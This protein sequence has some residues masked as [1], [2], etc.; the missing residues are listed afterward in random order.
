MQ[1]NGKDLQS[2]LANGT[3]YRGYDWERKYRLLE[4]YEL[5]SKRVGSRRS[6]HWER[7]GIDVGAFLKKVKDLKS[8]SPLLYIFSMLNLTPVKLDE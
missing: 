4:P 5:A 6:V 1:R 8:V 3:S 2:L 7:K